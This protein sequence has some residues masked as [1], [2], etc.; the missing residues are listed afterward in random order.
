MQS[1]H[2]KRS[3]LPSPRKRLV[4]Q[5][6]D[7]R[8]ASLLRQMCSRV[9][10]QAGSRRQGSVVVYDAARAGGEVR[11]ARGRE[12]GALR[13]GMAGYGECCGRRRAK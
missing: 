6:S 13:T 10:R 8:S 2:A 1:N 5:T 4:R 11:V 9:C 3:L 12:V 7:A